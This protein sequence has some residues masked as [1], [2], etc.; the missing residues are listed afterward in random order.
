MNV[1]N[2]KK[3]VIFTI[4]SMLLS[5]CVSN[6]AFGVEKLNQH[7]EFIEVDLENEGIFEAFYFEE[8]FIDGEGNEVVIGI[9]FEPN[10]DFIAERDY[11]LSARFP[12]LQSSRNA[13]VGVAT[14]NV[15]ISTQN[16]SFVADVGRSGNAWTLSNPRSHGFR[17]A[18]T[19]FSN[20]SL[21]L[22][23]GASTANFPAEITADVTA[24]YAG[25][26]WINIFTSTWNM[27]GTVTNNGVI[28]IYHN[29]TW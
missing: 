12:T 22:I 7:V 28:R 9:H 11:E 1:N 20:P 18:L 19:S 17:A 21:R 16:H 26:Q 25:N 4:F 24:H 2:L 13:S 5:M 10:P 27:R 14:F 15:T 6:V 3:T 8:I 29:T 23:R